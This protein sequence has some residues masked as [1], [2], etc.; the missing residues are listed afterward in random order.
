MVVELVLDLRKVFFL[1]LFDIDSV[2]V[3][4]FRYSL[5]EG[6]FKSLELVAL[7][8]SGLSCTSRKVENKTFIAPWIGGRRDEFRVRRRHDEVESIRRELRRHSPG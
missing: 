8:C 2:F 4:V 6:N 5:E 1:V 7:S 3:C